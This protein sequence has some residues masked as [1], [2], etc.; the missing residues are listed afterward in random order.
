[1]EFLTIIRYAWLAYDST[2]PIKRISDI[3]AMV[4]TNHVYKIRLEDGHNIIAKL[5]YF[6]KYEHF[7]E[8]HTI[9]NVLGNNL[10]VRYENFLSRALMKGNQLFFH[11]FQNDII[12]AWVVF[13]RPIKI[14]KSLPR[15]LNMSHIEQL[16]EQFADFHKSCHLVRHTLPVTSKNMTTDINQ[17]LEVVDDR[18]SKHADQIKEQCEIFLNNTYRINVHGFDKIPVFVDWNI[19][20]FSVNSKSNFYSRWDYDWFRMS[21]RIVDFY[22]ISRIV[23]NVGD[24]TVFT[25]NVE[26]IMEDRFLHFL[27]AYHRVYP[28]TRPEVEFIKEAYRFFLLNYVIREGNYFFRPS[29]A[30]QLQKDVLKV[31]LKT[32][33]KKFE[34]DRLLRVL[35]L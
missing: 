20:N 19:G 34:L 25:Y 9:I 8:D 27:K 18:F 16:G 3:S 13:F 33:D 4:S 17:L 15:R 23:S 29:I 5:S 30:K 14:K 1:M 12:D 31:H 26:T 11:R 7:V 32:I 2:R 22:F 6:G 35:E 10:P 24:K 21:S 28:L